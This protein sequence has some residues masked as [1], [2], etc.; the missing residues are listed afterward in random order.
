M[1][2]AGASAQRAYARVANGPWRRRGHGGCDGGESRR[3]ARSR[4]AFR[5][6]ESWSLLD[7]MNDA[8]QVPLDDIRPDG[9]DEM[10]VE[11]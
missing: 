7:R 10:D 2:L 3:A 6:A 4:S 9:L 1:A 5:Q 8:A 11:S